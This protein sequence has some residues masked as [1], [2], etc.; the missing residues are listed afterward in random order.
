MALARD[1]VAYEI[2]S[3]AKRI[4]VRENLKLALAFDAERLHARAKRGGFD[5]KKLRCAVFAGDFPF[6]GFQ[7]G[8]DIV[9][10]QLFEFFGCKHSLNGRAVADNRRSHRVH[11]FW[12]S[13]V[14]IEP[15]GAR[16]NH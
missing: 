7:S 1:F 14:E 9:A 2:S 5:A 16:R 6:G 11:A 13:A 10:L 3:E 8:D 12:Q 4:F 15:T